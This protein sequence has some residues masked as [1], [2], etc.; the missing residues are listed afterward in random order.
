MDEKLVQAVIKHLDERMPKVIDE[1]MQQKLAEFVGPMVAAETRKVVEALRV[2]RALIG[3]DRTGLS[4]EQKTEFVKNVKSVAFGNY[5]AKANEELIEEQDSRGGYLVSREVASAVVRIAASVGVVMSQA[6]KWPLKTDELGI[7]AYTGAFL[8]GEY[9]GVNAAGSLTGVT[10]DQANLIT[11]KWQLAFTVGNDL[12]ADASVDLADWLLSLAG[13]ALANMVD[14]QAFKAGAAPF[15]SLLDNANVTVHTMPTGKDTFAEFD[16]DEASDVIGLV[17][18]AVLSGA[19]WLFERTVWAKIRIKKDTAG[20]YVLPQAGAPS[21]TLLQDYRGVIGGAKP[22]GEI[23]G[24]PVFTVRHLPTNA[25]TAVS[26]KFGIFGNLAAVAYGDKGELRVM[27]AES[28][29]FG[30]KEIALADQ[31]ALIYKH[32]HAL[33]TTLPKAFVA[34]KTAAS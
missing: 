7:P 33:V 5:R 23:M 28:G 14:K 27:Q 10:F 2:E 30:G 12:I 24:Y 4:D 26:T 31:R 32:R 16:L 19:A 29:T 9:L 1:V 17:E 8:E 11:K 34:I 18:E 6:T 21:A 20:N 22:V 3:R 13:E 25:A 15:V